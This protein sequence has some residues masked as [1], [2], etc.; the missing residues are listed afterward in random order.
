MAAISRPADAGPDADELVRRV[1]AGDRQSFALIVRRYQDQVWKVA[2]AMLD[3]RV[4]AE[5]MVQQTFLNAYQHMDQY[6]L[7]RDLGAWLKAIARN[8]V[9]EEMRKR[10]RE[11]DVMVHYH[12]YM[13]TLLE[14]DTGVEQREASEERAMATCRGELA[15]AA[16]RALTLYYDEGR[17]TEDVARALGRTVAATRL[18]V[19]RARLALRRC[20]EQRL[21]HA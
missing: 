4:T 15:P 11:S 13:T 3:D 10:S 5:N 8:L 1:R 7:G 9:R 6:Q 16:A 2:A 18:L 19:F 14:D 21:G 17:S 20:V 12:A